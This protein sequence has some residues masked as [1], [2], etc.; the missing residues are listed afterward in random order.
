VQ[1][2]EDDRTG[3]KFERVLKMAVCRN[4]CNLSSGIWNVKNPKPEGV[5]VYDRFN[6]FDQVL[7]SRTEVIPVVWSETKRRDCRV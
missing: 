1:E 6:R 4:S 7:V 5:R 3:R 2:S